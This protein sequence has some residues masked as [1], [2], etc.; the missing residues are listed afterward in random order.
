MVIRVAGLDLS[1][2]SAGLA[3]LTVDDE[4]TPST[5]TGTF[6]Y[7]LDETATIVERWLRLEAIASEIDEHVDDATDLVVVEGPALNTNRP[8][9]GRFDLWGG[10]WLVADRLLSP[11]RKRRGHALAVVTPAQR[12]MYATGN[13][14]APKPHV[15]EAVRRHYGRMFDIPLGPATGPAGD[16]AD[17]AVLAAMGARVLDH[18]IDNPSP[19]HLRALD[20]VRWPHLEN[21]TA[22]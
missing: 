20:R 3:R 2:R 16:I 21:R 9:A 4:G 6:G 13:G 22:P 14:R 15:L 18:P 7:E 10:W 8:Q 5:W 17:G 1:T 12:A 19:L 11:T